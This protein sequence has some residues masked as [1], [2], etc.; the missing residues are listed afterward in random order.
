M[1]TERKSML[2]AGIAY[3]IF[4]LSYLFSKMA[5]GVTEPTI[6][7]FVRFSI[8]FLILNV[9]V[10]TKVMKLNL[11]GKKL[12][13]PVLV[14]ILQPVLYFIL[15]NYGLKYTTTSFTGIVSSISPIFTAILGV[16]LLR[17]K[18]NLRQWI[19]IVLSILGVL[20]VSL[21]NP[22]GENTLV[23]CLCLLGAY[24]VGALY[25]ILIRSLSKD[26]SA[27]ELTY[28]M[29]VIGFVFFAGLTFVQYGGETVPMLATALSDGKFIL[30]ALYLGGLS[31]VVAYLLSNYALAHLPVTRAT[32]F[33][34]F[35]TLVSV[36]SGV[37]LMGDPF[38][39]ISAIAFLLILAGVT[40]VNRFADKKTT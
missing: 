10:L 19:C 20:M 14:G 37:I 21:G 12:G 38:T 40:G 17:E 1:S 23:G 34:S 11:R 39:V 4:G 2:A 18:P 13:G 28:I 33:N 24:F 30:A 25:S 16:I 29:F 32:I 26:F 7:L 9:L 15:E 35:A 5:L 3:S 6:L 22:G 36:L 27:F 8:T 31:S